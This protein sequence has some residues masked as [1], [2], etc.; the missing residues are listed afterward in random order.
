MKPIDRLTLLESKSKTKRKALPKLI[1]ICRND[2]DKEK[3]RAEFT[4]NRHKYSSL[5]IVNIIG[6]DMSK[7]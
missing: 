2:A 5:R 7:K 3:A 1:R 4:K 6:V